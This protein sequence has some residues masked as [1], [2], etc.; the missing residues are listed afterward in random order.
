MLN[1]TMYLLLDEILANEEDNSNK[2]QMLWLFTRWDILD[3]LLSSNS[4]TRKKLAA[5][6]WSK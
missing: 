3:K 2:Y 6:D 4:K 1:Q 5:S